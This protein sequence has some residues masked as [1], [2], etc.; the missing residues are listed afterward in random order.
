VVHEEKLILFID[1]KNFYHGARRAFFPDDA[2]HYYGQ[3]NPIELGQLV[4]SR[5]LLTH[6]R[7]LYQVR[8]YTGAPEAT[9]EPKTYSAHIKQRTAWENAGIEVISRTLH[10][11]D[12]W[13]SSKAEQKGVDVAL[14]VDFVALAIDG[15]YDVGIIAS[16]DSDLKPA[17]EYVRRKCNDKCHIEVVAWN[18]PL[19]RSRLS[20]SEHNIWCHWLD[21]TDYD[22]IADLTDYNL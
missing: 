19:K 9:K 12:D 22:S 20:I 3:I 21:K 2:P 15:E 8:V 13:P 6:K 17:L 18:N 1:D 10:Y 11:P 14:A 4:C 16:T 7:K 5:S